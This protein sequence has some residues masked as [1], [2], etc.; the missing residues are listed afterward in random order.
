MQQAQL[1]KEF[2]EAWHDEL[3][4]QAAYQHA[5][6]ATE[7]LTKEFDKF[8]AGA[9]ARPVEQLD[10]TAIS[11]S[12][13]TLDQLGKQL[14]VEQ[15]RYHQLVVNVAKAEKAERHK[16]TKMIVLAVIALWILYVLF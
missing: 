3:A 14:R 13:D 2:S 16:K 1:V 7:R 12:I 10:F 5:T 8:R 9:P 4:T 6:H 11:R 15:D